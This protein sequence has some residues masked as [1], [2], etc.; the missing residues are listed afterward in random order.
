MKIL[1]RNLADFLLYGNFFIAL[2]AVAMAFQ[3]CHLRYFSV[4]GSPLLIFIFSS[5]FFLYNSHKFI[6]FYLKKEIIDNQRFI[7]IKR[8]DAPLSILTFIALLL[9]FDT[10][11]MLGMDIKRDVA[12]I[13]L[14][15]MLYVLPVFK[16]KRLRDLPYLKIFLITGVWVCVCVLLPTL[17]LGKAWWTTDAIIA[18]EKA[19]FI[20]ALTIPFDI[21]DR[22]WDKKL[23]VKTIPLS[24]G[25]PSDNIGVEKS[26]QLAYKCLILSFLMSCIL[27]FSKNYSYW[28]LFKLGLSLII[29]YFV[30]KKTD[31]SKDDYFYLFC[32][33]GMML[34]QSLI[35]ILL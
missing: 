5:T 13:A 1:L 24:L 10:Y 20:F 35:V 15:S 30:I 4:A 27:I 23:G 12:L 11:M 32:I 6:T 22:A 33:D 26:K 9:S 7:Y 19:F 28:T 25:S 21:R 3:T 14:P 17:A 34:L 16:G 8:F 2:C 29:T 31:D 18:F